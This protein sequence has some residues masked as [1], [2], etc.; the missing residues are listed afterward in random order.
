MEKST[1]GLLKLAVG[2]GQKQRSASRIVAFIRRFSM[3]QYRQQ[4]TIADQGG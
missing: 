2:S 3:D 1:L 4:R